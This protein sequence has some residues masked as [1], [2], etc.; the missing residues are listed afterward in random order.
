LITD[1]QKRQIAE[2]GYLAVENFKSRAQIA[3][4]KGAAAAIINA[5]DFA[6]HKAIFSTTN[7][8]ATNNAYFLNSGDKIR[9]FFEEGAFDE[10]GALK[11]PIEMSI[12][13]IGHAMHDLDPVFNEFSRDDRLARLLAGLGLDAPKIWQSMYIFKQPRIG[14]EVR[15]HQ[16]ATYFYTEPISVKTLWFALDDATLENGCL[17]VSKAGADTPLRERFSIVDGEGR[18]ERL[19][20]TPWPE[21]DQAIPLEVGAGTLLCFDGLL[22]HYSAPNHSSKPRHAYTLHIADG[23]CAYPASNWLQRTAAFPARGF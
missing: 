20:E 21:M 14:G 3:A 5:F 16:D 13:K 6:A 17:W 19:D 1:N 8:K 11:Q 7:D 2:K 22:P 15:W 12:N 9:C 10:H 4:L 18:L 23:R